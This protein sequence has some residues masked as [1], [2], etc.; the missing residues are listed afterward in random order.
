MIVVLAGCAPDKL[1]LASANNS[2]PGIGLMNVLLAT[3]ALDMHHR[4]SFIFPEP[5]TINPV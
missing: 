5:G 2:L 1:E 3:H 4:A